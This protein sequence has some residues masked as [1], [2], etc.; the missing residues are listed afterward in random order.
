MEVPWSLRRNISGEL[1]AVKAYFNRETER[2]AYVKQ[3]WD[4]REREKDEMLKLQALKAGVGPAHIPTDE[5][6]TIKLRD[7]Y[8]EFLKFEASI[9]RE[10]GLKDDDDQPELITAI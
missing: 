9:L 6:V 4:I 7:E 1:Q 5:E 3:R 10:M 8:N 2:R